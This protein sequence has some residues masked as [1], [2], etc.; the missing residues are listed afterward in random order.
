MVLAVLQARMSSTRLPGKVLR[1]ILGQPMIGRQ[2]ERLHRSRR[3][4]SIVVATSTGAEDD[5]LAAYAQG[6][7]LAVFRGALD[8]V[9]DRFHGAIA[10]H[11]GGG[12]H[13]VRL[14]ADCPLTDPA[15]IDAMI[16]HHV[17]TGADWTNNSDGATYPKGLDAEVCRISA[18]ETA[19]REAADPYEREHV[20]PFLYRHPE[21]FRLEGLTRHPPLRYRWTVDTAEDLDFVT[22]VYEALYPGKPDFTSQD[23]LDWQARNPGRVLVN[24]V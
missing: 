10:A 17:A 6:L 18:L 20:T 4:S 14:T 7:G 3:L 5:P 21:R 13:M 1:P 19:W 24:A 2:V 9:L 11:S 22:T 16:E 12:E 15:L 8:D 23:V